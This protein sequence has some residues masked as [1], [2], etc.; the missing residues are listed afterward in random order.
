MARNKL[1]KSELIRELHRLQEKLDR[2]PSTTDMNKYGEYSAPPYYR[3]FGSWNNA[4]KEAGYEPIE[5]AER[6]SREE[7]LSELKRVA[8]E[9]DSKPS[10]NDMADYG[11]PS[12]E[13]YRAKFGSWN[14]ALEAAGFTRRA[15]GNRISDEDL[16]VALQDLT[17]ELDRRPKT[18]DMNQR[19]PYS[20]GTYINR[21]GSWEKA[22]DTADID[23]SNP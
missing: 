16:C 1:T 5:T 14:A 8:E 13:T 22:L 3:V 9:C 17:D 10:K 4:L 18:S 6:R 11:E 15:N 21:F 19:G 23:P 7:L 12:P 2:P 20:A